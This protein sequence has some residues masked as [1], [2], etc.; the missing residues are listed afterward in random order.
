[1]GAVSHL[2]LGDSAPS[3]GP[4]GRHGKNQ[5]SRLEQKGSW[6]MVTRSC[7]SFGFSGEKLVQTYLYPTAGRGSITPWQWYLCCRARELQNT[8]S[9]PLSIS[10]FCLLQVIWPGP[11]WEQGETSAGMQE[12]HASLPGRTPGWRTISLMH[13]SVSRNAFERHAQQHSQS[14]SPQMSQGNGKVN[15]L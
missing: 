4:A 13:T 14:R 7:Q 11:G 12:R 8:S 9:S 3:K 1:M 10:C 2:I 15:S 6:F 5:Q